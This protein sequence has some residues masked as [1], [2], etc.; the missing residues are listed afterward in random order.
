MNEN[1]FID[2]VNK[3]ERLSDLERLIYQR[4]DG[5]ASRTDCKA[6]VGKMVQLNRIE[7]KSDRRQFMADLIE[8]KR[9]FFEIVAR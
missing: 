9:Q 3:C 6:L 4:A 5:R 2:R 1:D 8:V 7:A